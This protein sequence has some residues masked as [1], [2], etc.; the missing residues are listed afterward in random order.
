M[1]PKKGK[2]ITKE[3]IDLIGARFSR[4][5]GIVYCLSRNE[6]DQVASNLKKAGIKAVS[7]HAGLTDKARASVQNDWLSDRAKVRSLFTHAY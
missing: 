2:S 1:Y 3:I 6:C 4:Q 5:S 7:Y